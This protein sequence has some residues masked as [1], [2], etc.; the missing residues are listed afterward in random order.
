MTK[1]SRVKSARLLPA[2]WPEASSTLS[3][4]RVYLDLAVVAMWAERSDLTAQH[5]E[6]A[7]VRAEQASVRLRSVA[8]SIRE[9]GLE[10]EGQ[11]PLWEE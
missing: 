1:T 6:A 2:G 11:L 5:L 3:D 4:A 10:V 8:A 7:A 9:V